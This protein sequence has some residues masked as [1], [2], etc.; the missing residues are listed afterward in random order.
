MWLRRLV[1]EQ[2]SKS[3]GD[4][5]FHA[6]TEKGENLLA[7]SR[8]AE[9]E[10]RRSA[11]TLRFAR[12]IDATYFDDLVYC[13]CREDLYAKHFRVALDTA[14]PGGA[15]FARGLLK[16]I[17]RARNQLCHSNPISV[18]SA[19]QVVCYSND[20]IESLKLYYKELGMTEEYNVPSVIRIRDSFGS[21]TPKQPRPPH[22]RTTKE[23]RN[24]DQSS[25][26]RPGEV[27]TIEVEVDPS[28]PSD[29]YEINWSV[30]GT[31]LSGPK[32]TIELDKTHVG[33]RLR[34]FCRVVSNEDWHRYGDC[35]DS[36]FIDYKVLPPPNNA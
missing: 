11:D 18:R 7:R 16:K 1:D 33:E 9:I 21:L 36:L 6:K 12:L 26:L 8:V 3:Y 24:K 15:N 19:E 22:A 20:V 32:I 29:S 28:F 10:D 5:Y 2:F 30:G 27:L 25:Y 34:F 23:R 14:F 31:R 17:Q 13:V 35:D 4:D